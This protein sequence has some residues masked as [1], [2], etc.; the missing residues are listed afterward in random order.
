MNNIILAKNRTCYCLIQ[1]SRLRTIH[2]WCLIQSYYIYFYE[3]FS[4]ANG[5][6]EKTHSIKSHET[7]VTPYQ[8]LKVL[9]ICKK[10]KYF[11]GSKN[12]KK[13]ISYHESHLF[14]RKIKLLKHKYLINGTVAKSLAPWAKYRHKPI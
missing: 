3:M 1:P 5:R 14:K 13:V 7:Y 4:F 8:V 12:G 10:L 2:V 6:Q 9:C 11:K